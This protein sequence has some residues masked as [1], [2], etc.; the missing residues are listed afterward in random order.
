MDPNNKKYIGTYEFLHAN[1]NEWSDRKD[2]FLF[3]PELVV[4]LIDVAGGFYT[5]QTTTRVFD[6]L[7]EDM[8]YLVSRAK[9]SFNERK[10]S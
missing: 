3:N 1:L 6:H 2:M 8:I 9:D 7:K 10:A 5:S 4:K